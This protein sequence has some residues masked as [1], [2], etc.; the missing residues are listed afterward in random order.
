[1]KMREDELELSDKVRHLT[2]GFD[3]EILYTMRLERDAAEESEEGYQKFL[4]AIRTNTAFFF[5]GNE[6]MKVGARRTKFPSS[7]RE[8]DM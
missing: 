8:S 6:V 5:K 4:K 3:E 2:S 1:M 7:E